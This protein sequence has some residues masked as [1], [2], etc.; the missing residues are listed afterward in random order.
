MIS[1]PNKLGSVFLLY[2]VI[3][4]EMMLVDPE[5]L[6]FSFSKGLT[7]S[8]GEGEN[9]FSKEIMRMLPK[10]VMMFPRQRKT[11]KNL[12]RNTNPFFQKKN[13]TMVV[14]IEQFVLYCSG[15]STLV[16]RLSIP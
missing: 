6:C 4:M 15:V 16:P 11:K 10:N 12:R 1:T 7:N 8:G 2:V 13:L 9:S 5:H 14:H 3:K